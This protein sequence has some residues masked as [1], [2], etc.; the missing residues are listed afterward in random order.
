MAQIDFLFRQGIVKTLGNVLK[1]QQE[2]EMLSIALEALINI[3][4][5]IDNVPEGIKNN[6]PTLEDFSNE[7]ELGKLKFYNKTIKFLLIVR[8]FFSKV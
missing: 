3:A 6:Y 5:C 2:D 7:I 1:Q 4:E 8:I